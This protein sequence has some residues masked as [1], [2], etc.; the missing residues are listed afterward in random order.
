MIGAGASGLMAAISAA[1]R[2]RKVLVVDHAGRPGRKLLVSGGGKCNITNRRVSVADYYGADPSFTKFALKQWTTKKTFDML[3]KAG[4]TTEE[5]DFGRIFCRQGAGEV[6][7]YLV[8]TAQQLGVCFAFHS[9]VSEVSE[10]TNRMDMANAGSATT[11]HVP[12]YSLKSFFQ[13]RC[14]DIQYEADSLLVATGGLAWPQLGATNLGYSI[15]RQF[16]HKIKPLKPALTGFVLAE[17]APLMHLQGI[18]L[19]VRLQIKGKKEV[20]EEPLLF[21][22]KGFSGPA[23]LQLSCFWE[24]GDEVQINFLPSEDLLR[25]MHEPANGKWLVKNLVMQF[26]PERLVKSILPSDLADRKVAELSKKDRLNITT[27]VHSYPVIPVDV[28]GFS[29][30][31]ATLGGVATNEINPKTMESLLQKG[32]FFSGEVIDI[33]GRLGGYNIHWAFASGWVAGQYL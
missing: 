17:D 4:I 8:R 33:T 12:G 30:A 19:H 24:Q 5:R 29:K 7:S 26:L 22:H 15:A 3:D 28:E 10:M 9:T 25:Q 2:G 23:S 1:T 11:V 32:L 20:V 27:C 13:I 14:D 31:E 6:V 18:S 16:G 21:T